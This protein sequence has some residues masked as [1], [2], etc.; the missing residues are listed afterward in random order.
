MHAAVIIRR[1]FVYKRSTTQKE[2]YDLENDGQ[3][4]NTTNKLFSKSL[5]K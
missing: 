2:L 3:S 1:N 5:S 4:K